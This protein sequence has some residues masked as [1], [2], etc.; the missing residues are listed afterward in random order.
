M[1]WIFR[2]V[3]SSGPFRAT[4][5]K[6]GVGMSWGIPGFRFGISSSGRKYFNLGIPGTGLYFVKYLDSKTNNQK[7]PPKM[8][9]DKPTEL[10]KGDNGNG[11][12]WW[13]QNNL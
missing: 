6:K 5:S 8:E 4:V 1:R 2:K 10:D 3:F 12:P 9:I 7:P 13:E 11:F